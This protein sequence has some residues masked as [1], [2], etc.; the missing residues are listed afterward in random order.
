MTRTVYFDTTIFIEMLTK[1]SKHKARIRELLAE[2]KDKKVRV[3]TSILTV[4]ELAVA[5]YR[6]GTLSRD[7]YGDIYSIARV[8]GL[9][10]EISLTAAKFEAAL[11]DSA[12][13][14]ARKRDPKKPE[15]ED[16]KLERM[17]ENRRRKWDCIH[18]ASA[19][20]IGCAEVYSTD[21]K[22]QKR[23]G[24]LGIKSFKVIGPPA[25]VKTVK[26]PLLDGIGESKT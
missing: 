25:A 2:L 23:P 17:C 3:Y 11:K 1:R 6:A 14:E 8:Y 18:L 10:K 7:T 26:G 21:E 20:E 15:P 9:T 16:A 19:M 22:L 24:H 4:Q 5:T 12:D 13:E